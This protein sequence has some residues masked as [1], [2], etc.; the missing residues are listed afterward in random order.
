ML[1]FKHLLLPLYSNDR[2]HVG[3]YALELDEGLDELETLYG[4]YNS[5]HHL[6]SITRLKN[7]QTF[8]ERVCDNQRR[9][10]GGRA[11]PAPPKI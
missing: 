7:L 9:R 2:V 4:F 8:G 10:E 6:K 3:N 11:V 1:R 5:R